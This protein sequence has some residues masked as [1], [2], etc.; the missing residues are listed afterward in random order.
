METPIHVSFLTESVAGLGHAALFQYNFPS[1]DRWTV[2]AD[3]SDSR[4]LAEVLCIGFWRQL[5]GPFGRF[6]LQQRFA[7]DYPDVTV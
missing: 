5:G 4:G 3:H 2:G 7:F 1:A 6:R